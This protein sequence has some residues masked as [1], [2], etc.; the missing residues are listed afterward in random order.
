MPSPLKRRAS[1]LALVSAWRS[2]RAAPRQ[3]NASRRRRTRPS[4]TVTVPRLRQSGRVWRWGHVARPRRR[5]RQRTVQLRT[6]VRRLSCLAHHRCSRRADG[7]PCLA[8]W[9]LGSGPRPTAPA[10]P[11]RL[12]G[13]STRET[14]CGRGCTGHAPRARR[15]SSRVA[16]IAT[17]RPTISVVYTTNNYYTLDESL[18]SAIAKGTLDDAGG[19]PSATSWAR[20]SRSPCAPPAAPGERPPSATRR[21]SSSPRPSPTARSLLDHGR[22]RQQRDQHDPAGFHVGDEGTTT[23]LTSAQ[24]VQPVRAE[25]IDGG[26]LTPQFQQ[27]FCIGCHSATPDRQYVSFTTQWP[28]PTALASIQSPARAPAS[29]ALERSHA[30]PQP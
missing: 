20:R 19:S 18:W 1:L 23:A 7:Q 30:E 6:Q 3:R 9:G 8:L 27:V 24:V 2:R 5:R 12:M 21:R 26:N 29:V 28:W 14:G 22:L 16:S 4:A 10:S 17:R 25:P 15:P 11:S 13:R